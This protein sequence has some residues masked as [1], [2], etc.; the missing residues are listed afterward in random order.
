MPGFF[1]SGSYTTVLFGIVSVLPAAGGLLAWTAI[2]VVL[3]LAPILAMFGVAARVVIA[4]TPIAPANVP[5]AG[6]L[7][8]A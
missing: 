4:E 7:L 3:G 8:A 6:L 2:T 5:A 1:G